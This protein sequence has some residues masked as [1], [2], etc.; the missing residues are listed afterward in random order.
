MRTAAVAN[1]GPRANT[2][3]ESQL[4]PI[5]FQSVIGPKSLINK[6]RSAREKK[7]RTGHGLRAAKGRISRSLGRRFQTVTFVRVPQEGRGAHFNE[8]IG[9]WPPRPPIARLSFLPHPRSD[10]QKRLRASG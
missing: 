7:K 10:R 5:S 6:R 3:A 4:A 8:L 9:G 2:A 1:Q